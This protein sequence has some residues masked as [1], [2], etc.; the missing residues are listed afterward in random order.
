MRGKKGLEEDILLIFYGADAVGRMFLSFLRQLQNKPFLKWCIFQ[1]QRAEVCD[2]GLFWNSTPQKQ[3]ILPY[4]FRFIDFL[5][6][7]LTLEHS[8]VFRIIQR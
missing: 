3:V 8:K 2:W 5:S 4:N 6:I 7:F 1:K